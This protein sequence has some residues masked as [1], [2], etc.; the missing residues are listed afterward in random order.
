MWRADSLE[1]ILILG[2]IEGRRRRGW[3]RTRWSDDIT[4]SK[5]VSLSKLWEMVKDKE[6]WSAAVRGSQRVG[7]NWATEQQ[8]LPREESTQHCSGFCCNLEENFHNVQSPWFPANKSRKCPQIPLSRNPLQ[9]VQFSSVAQSCPTLCDPMNSSTP[10]LP[11]HHQLPEFSQTHVHRVGDAIQS[12]HLLSS[13]LLLPSS[14]PSIRVFSIE[15]VLPI[16]WPQ[17]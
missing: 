12:S 6:A 9:S 17:Y 4:V 13:L 1:K 10:G 8:M 16:M 14:F 15:S 2:K 11:V 5:D 3:Q 7:H